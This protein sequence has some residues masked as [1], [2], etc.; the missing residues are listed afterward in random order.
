ML[1]FRCPLPYNKQKE[2]ERP[3]KKEKE[4]VCEF[5]TTTMPPLDKK[6]TVDD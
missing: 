5:N 2:L 1:P 3:A 4:G 6:D